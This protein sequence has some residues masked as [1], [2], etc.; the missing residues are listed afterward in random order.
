MSY[1]SGIMMGAAFGKKLHDYIKGGAQVSRIISKPCETKKA[2]K[3]KRGL[4][5]VHAL[6]GR[7]RYHTDALYGDLPLIRLLQEELIKLDFI[8]SV[9]ADAMTG[10]LLL[11]YVPESE[12]QVDALAVF[13]ENRIFTNTVSEARPASSVGENIIQ[14]FSS[15]NAI[16]RKKTYGVFDL[17]SLLSVWFIIRG[18]RKIVMQGQY[19]AG[20]QMLWWAFSLLR[21]WR[22]AC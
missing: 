2:G 4:T 14:T 18:I 15:I 11:V 10:S 21:G 6:P 22:M 16:V 1:M 12:K 9:T 20:P 17:N 19:P 5:L 7:R 3:V 13:L 8:I